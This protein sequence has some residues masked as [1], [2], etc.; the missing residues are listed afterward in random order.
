MTPKT[1]VFANLCPKNTRLSISTTDFIPC[2]H[3][4]VCPKEV[5]PAQRLEA[6]ATRGRVRGETAVEAQTPKHRLVQGQLRER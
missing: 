1:H 5:R 6:R 4:A 2:I 3:S